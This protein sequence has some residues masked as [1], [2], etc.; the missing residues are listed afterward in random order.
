MYGSKPT[1]LEEAIETAY[2]LTENHVLKGTLT[3]IGSKKP[4][5]STT[6]TTTTTTP[7]ASG[8]S[9]K[10]K[11][12]KHGNGKNFVVVAQPNQAPVAQTPPVK[13]Q[14]TGTLPKCPACQYHHSPTTPCMKCTNCGRN[15]HLAVT[16]RLAARAPANP[17]P[18][19]QHQ[20]FLAGTCFHCGD[21]THFRP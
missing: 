17:Q 4:T 15:G 3:R 19:A 18:A 20:W 6:T 14:Y 10:N 8:S 2:Q 9:S 16:C 7:A 21:P 1:T 11:K 13:K 12:R 5:E